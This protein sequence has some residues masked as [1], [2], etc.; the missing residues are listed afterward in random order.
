MN[1]RMVTT[2]SDAVEAAMVAM[3]FF[4]RTMPP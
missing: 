4:L 3:M 1:H 2:I